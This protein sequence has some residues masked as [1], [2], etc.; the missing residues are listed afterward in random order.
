MHVLS[1]SYS[2]HRDL[3]GGTDYAEVRIVKATSVRPIA[4]PAQCTPERVT[5]HFNTVTAPAEA[6]DAPVATG[7]MPAGVWP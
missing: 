2:S 5:A 7:L 3:S 6:H 1:S 4:D